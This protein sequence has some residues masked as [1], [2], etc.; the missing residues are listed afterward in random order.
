MRLDVRDSSNLCSCHLKKVE[1]CCSLQVWTAC[2]TSSREQ[3]GKGEKNRK[4][5]V[6]NLTNTT[7]AWRSRPMAAAVNQAEGWC[8]LV[9][10]DDN[11]SLPLMVFLSKTH[12]LSLIMRKTSE[13]PL[14]RD[15]IKYD[16][17]TS[18]LSRSSKTNKQKGLR[19][20]QKIP[21]YVTIKSTV[22]SWMELWDRKKALGKNVWIQHY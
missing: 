18:K 15:T 7:L 19:S 4:F 2:V 10:R 20:C 1:H 5:A 14:L 3:Y 13:K 8:V 9:R 6:G 11:G 12:C 22:A 21:R 17:N 16:W